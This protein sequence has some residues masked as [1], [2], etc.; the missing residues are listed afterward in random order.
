MVVVDPRKFAHRVGV[1]LLRTRVRA[2]EE[3]VDPV[4]PGQHHAGV[5]VRAP[6]SAARHECFSSF[7]PLVLG[8]F[9]SEQFA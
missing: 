5:V 6:R 7:G 3:R 1:V 8:R 9:A 4:D 2:C